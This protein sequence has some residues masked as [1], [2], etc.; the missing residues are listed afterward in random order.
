MPKSNNLFSLLFA[1]DTTGLARGPNLIELE[2]FVN[3]EVQKLGEWLRSNKL[4]INASKTKIMIFKPNNRPLPLMRFVFNDNDVLSL[5]NSNP[6]HEIEI[7]S[8]FKFLGVIIDNKL[9]FDNIS[10]TCWLSYLKPC[11]L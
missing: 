1:D 7:V 9:S 5:H 10:R 3:L 2:K 4:A 11:T 8:S 6:I